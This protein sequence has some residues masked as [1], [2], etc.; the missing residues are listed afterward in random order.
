VGTGL[1]YTST[2][3]YA[4]DE[5]EVDE[6]F[7]LFLQ[8]FLKLHTSYKERPIYFTGE[9]HAGTSFGLFFLL[10]LQVRQH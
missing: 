6:Q 2:N 10:F 1:S 4:D 9:S 7:Y 5:A 8:N 3:D